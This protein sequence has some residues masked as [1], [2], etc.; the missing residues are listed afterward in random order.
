MISRLR[1][2]LAV[3]FAIAFLLT[4]SLVLASEIES[5]IELS[6][7][8]SLV[9]VG[10]QGRVSDAVAKRY[11][12]IGTVMLSTPRYFSAENSAALIAQSEK[13]GAALGKALGCAYNVYGDKKLQDTATVMMRSVRAG[14]VAETAAA[15]FATLAENGYAFDAVV[16]ILHEASELVRASLLPDR[17]TALCARIRKLA[18]GKEK[19]QSLQKEIMFASVRERERQE[20]LL[21]QNTPDVKE[22]GGNGDRAPS[23]RRASSSGSG[24]SS[25]IASSAAGNSTAGRGS[26]NG[27]ENADS[28]TTS[29]SGGTNS[30]GSTGSESG[31]TNSGGGTGS[32]GGGTNGGASEGSGSESGG[33]NSGGSTGSEGGGTNSG[34]SSSNAE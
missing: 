20:K 7:K 1:R 14:L 26:S 5:I 4:P 32:E 28:N 11:V 12:F 9:A 25:A 30:G 22:R 13:T 23:S 2:F 15:T 31:G 16:S 24:G 17:G 27:N 18:S 8:E 19:V 34:E 3:S 29:E 21:A 6:M 33:T 10:V